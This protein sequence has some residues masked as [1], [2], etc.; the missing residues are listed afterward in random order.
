[1]KEIQ[2]I[3]GISVEVVS[4][5]DTWAISNEQVSLAFGV[6]ENSIRQQKTKGSTEY[7]EGVHFFNVSNPHNGNLHP[8][9]YWTKKGVITLGFKLRE[10][11]Q[12]IAFRD[13]ASDFILNGGE[14]KPMTIEQLLE[15]NTKMIAD[16]R[17]NVITLEHKI[18]EDKPKVSYA[19]AVVGSINP[20]SIR[21]WISAL[22]S[23]TGLQ[24]GERKVIAYLLEKKYIYRDPKG[25]LRAYAD[26]YDTPGNKKGY[27]S[28]IP[29]TTATPKGNREFGQLKVTGLGQLELGV[30]VV[31]HFKKGE[32]A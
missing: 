18:E 7:I 19:T 15:H 1:M 3:N 16:L 30:E 8:I 14:Y 12:T 23:D 2:T 9:T 5:Q 31:D 13:W 29:V 20:V 4:H 11:P 24:A 28:L 22:K 10:T 26:Y 32:S 21:D 6:T 17:N 25:N 27:F